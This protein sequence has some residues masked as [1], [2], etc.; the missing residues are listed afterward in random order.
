MIECIQFLRNSADLL[1]C[2]TKG[3]AAVLTRHIKW[4]NLSHHVHLVAAAVT[5]HFVSFC[6]PPNGLSC[7]MQS[8]RNVW[9]IRRGQYD[10]IFDEQID[11]QRYHQKPLTKV[12]L[13]TR[14][15]L[16]CIAW[17]EALWKPPASPSQVKLDIMA[18]CGHVWPCFKISLNTPQSADVFGCFS[19]ATVKSG[20]LSLAPDESLLL[21][22]HLRLPYSSWENSQALGI[23]RGASLL[24]L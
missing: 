16:P 14:R 13:A 9:K 4:R 6:C 19:Q 5:I 24:V 7:L 12:K 3:L 1:E 20:P 15:W 21:A 22:L 2:P 11:L 17:L 8:I 23:A 10:S 18:D